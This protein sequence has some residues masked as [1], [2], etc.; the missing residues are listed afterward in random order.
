MLYTSLLYSRA[1]VVFWNCPISLSSFSIHFLLSISSL[2]SSFPSFSVLWL[3]VGLKGTLQAPLHP[4]MKWAWAI[5][6]RLWRILGFLTKTLAA[7]LFSPSHLLLSPLVASQLL[8]LPSSLLFS[9]FLPSFLLLVPLFLPLSLPLPP[10]TLFFPFSLVDLHDLHYFIYIL[11]ESG[12]SYHFYKK[13]APL[14]IFE[15]CFVHLMIV[16]GKTLHK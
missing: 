16:H 10:G 4:C 5:A 7:P 12:R 9:L 15:L 11:I 3:S 8:L 1:L 6:G 14:L 2:Y 13:V